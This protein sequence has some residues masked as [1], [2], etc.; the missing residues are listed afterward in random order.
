LKEKTWKQRVAVLEKTLV[1]SQP[2]PSSGVIWGD[3]NKYGYLQEQ[4]FIII[5][6]IIIIINIF[7]VNIDCFL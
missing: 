2:H 7:A 3:Q 1:A 4:L 6:I 5:I